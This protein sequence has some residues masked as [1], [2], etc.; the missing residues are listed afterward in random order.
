LSFGSAISSYG[1]PD[2]PRQ[3]SSGACYPPPD[4][5]LITGKKGTFQDAKK[6]EDCLYVFDE[7]AQYID[8]FD[9]EFNRA[10]GRLVKDFQGQPYQINLKRGLV[11]LSEDEC[12][13]PPGTVIANT[14]PRYNTTNAE[15][16][17][18]FGNQE[19]EW[20]G[21]P[22][23][24]AAF[25]VDPCHIYVVPVVVNPNDGDPNTAYLAAA[26]L[27]LEPN[28]MPPYR[29][30]QLYDDPPL[31]GDNQNLNNLREIE[32]DST[33]KLYVLHRGALNECD[34]LLVYDKKT[35]AVLSR[36][37]LGNPAGNTYLPAPS[38]MYLSEQSGTLY[39]A[40]SQNDP[41]ASSVVLYALS[42]KDF[43][44]AEVADINDIG[45]ITDITGDDTTGTVWVVGFTMYGIFDDPN[46]PLTENVE[47]FYKSYIAK[48]PSGSGRTVQ[49]KCLSDPILYPDNDLA[50]PLSIVWTGPK[51]KCV[52]ADVDDSG[53]VNLMDFAALAHYWLEANCGLCGGAD[54]TN[55][56]NVDSNDLNTFC[57]CWLWELKRNLNVELNINN[58]WMYQNLPGAASSNLTAN[59]VV[60][61][62]PLNNSSYSYQWEFVL[63]SD[64]SLE[65][66]TVSGGGSRDTFWTFMARNCHQ[67][68]AMSD[69]GQVFR[70]IVTV[71]GSDHGNTGTAE[72]EFGIALLGDVNNDCIVDVADRSII[73]AF[74]QTSFAGK[75]TLRDCDL[76]CDGVVDVADCS[77]AN[78]LWCGTLCQNEVTIPCQFR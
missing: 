10:N 27:Q 74:W 70:I 22:I 69:S 18:G 76:N 56:G 72:K 8:K 77:I 31:P 21:R 32:V 28:L 51:D 24:D 59:V 57:D 58:L 39:L 26:R 78:A 13:V 53:K 45:H 29:V 1:Y 38:A 60:T 42:T 12:I 41:N 40:S 64:V 73:N 43:N 62:D 75:F 6:V 23:F 4:T 55:D 15:V 61:D 35:A 63:P 48:I 36:I 66:E 2:S 71:R 49:A 47:P 5:L 3:L 46:I 9:S 19:N 25:S 68:E 54:F 50:L 65:P 16:R 33:G 37:E 44:L 20:M 30:V 52:K 14:E 7:N 67:P 11:R 17:V 34:I